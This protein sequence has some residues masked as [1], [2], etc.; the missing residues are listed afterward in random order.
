MTT[1]E[2]IATEIGTLNEKDL[3]ELYALIKKFAD[4]KKRYHLN[5]SGE[6]ETSTKF[7]PRFH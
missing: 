6:A 5:I 4:S 3:N 2:L 1:K 7:C